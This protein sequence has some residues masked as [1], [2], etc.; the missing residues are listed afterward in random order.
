MVAV[1]FGRPLAFLLGGNPK[2]GGRSID[3]EGC[4]VGGAVSSSGTGA[5]GGAVSSSGT[6]ATGT[7]Y[8]I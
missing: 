5:T 3:E 2:F 1:F 8:G 4:A 6:G 7:E